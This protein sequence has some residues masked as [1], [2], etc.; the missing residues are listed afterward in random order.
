MTDIAA[1]LYVLKIAPG[2]EKTFMQIAD[3]HAFAELEHNFWWDLFAHDTVERA[4]FPLDGV[5]GFY[6]GIADRQREHLNSLDTIPNDARRSDIDN[7]LAPFSAERQYDRAFCSLNPEDA[8]IMEVFKTDPLAGLMGAWTR[9]RVV[10]PDF[11]KLP[12]GMQA[13]AMAALTRWAA[14]A[15]PP[16][17]YAP[18]WAEWMNEVRQ[19]EAAAQQRRAED[20]EVLSRLSAA[21]SAKLDDMQAEIA[22]NAKSRED[23]AKAAEAM[24]AEQN[25]RLEQQIDLY[26]NQLAIQSPVDYWRSRSRWQL[27]FATVW[28]VVFSLLSF[29]IARLILEGYGPLAKLFDENK[30]INLAM[31]PFLAAAA[32]PFVWLLKHV[33]RQFVDCMIDSRDASQRAVQAETYLALLERS[34]DQ[35]DKLKPD[36]SI[37][38]NALF[39]P[40]PAQPTED[41]I[42]LPLIELF[43]RH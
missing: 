38:L 6:R 12:L 20:A 23:A 35:P 28:I 32:L 3:I 37:A 33:S 21:A 17:A 18:A 15:A 42:P 34:K 22:A 13:E 10:K 27:S 5:R 14:G 43:K 30:N 26:K 40:G 4:G 29:I 39:R 2:I 11:S 36:L 19:H 8:R 31:V 7:R 16:A 25:D 1:P 24:R 9:A 41:G